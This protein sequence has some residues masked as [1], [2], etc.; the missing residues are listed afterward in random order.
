MA[1]RD[2]RLR[3][4]VKID[5]LGQVVPGTLI[6]RRK[7]P[8]SGRSNNWIEIEANECCSFPLSQFAFILNSGTGLFTLAVGGA[9][10]VSATNTE[11]GE[12]N[13]AGG[14]V[15][16]VTETGTGP[17]KTLL[18]VDNTSGVVLSNQVGTT[19]ALTFTYT[20]IANH[21]YT[22][23]G[24]QNFTTTT[25]TTTTTTS[26][27]TTSTTST[28]TTSTS[29][30]STTTT[31]TTVAAGLLRVVN[32][33]TVPAG[34][35]ITAVGPGTS[36]TGG[37]FPVAASG[38]TSMTLVTSTNVDLT[39]TIAATG[40]VGSATLTL[41]KNGALV[42]TLGVIT[43]PGTRTF[44]AISFTTADNLEIVLT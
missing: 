14:Q 2:P 5:N 3:A 1:K 30:T 38:A 6:L 17:Q 36:V 35:T 23:I 16:T 13:V 22:V 11:A 33:H 27:T 31:T 4:F 28:S 42:E 20:A 24:A 18:V 37:T 19:G 26:T 25:T 10:V 41:F 39:V 29:T 32:N 43:T 44:G 9:T 40:L 7:P 21:V 12:F 15:V 34:V 8:E